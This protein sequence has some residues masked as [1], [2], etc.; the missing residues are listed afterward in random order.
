MTRH[1]PER[2]PTEISGDPFARFGVVG[3]PS[4][5]A[6]AEEKSEIEVGGEV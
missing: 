4:E 2:I 3:R 1:S 6:S 5:S